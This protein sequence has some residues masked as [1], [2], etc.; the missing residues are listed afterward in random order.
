MKQ[1]VE[2]VIEIAIEYSLFRLLEKEIGNGVCKQP[3]KPL[4]EARVFV[5]EFRVHISEDRVNQVPEIVVLIN[6]FE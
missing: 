2:F 1:L 5:L 6:P 3:E 4:C